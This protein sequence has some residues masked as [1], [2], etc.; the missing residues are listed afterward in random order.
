MTVAEFDRYVQAVRLPAELLWRIDWT[1]QLLH[2]RRPVVSLKHSEVAAYCDWARVRLPTEEEWEWAAAGPERRRYPWGDAEP[3]PALANFSDSDLGAPTD[4]GSYPHGATPSGIHDMAGN[5]F[6]WT[7]S[8]YDEER[9]V[10]RGGCYET[11]AITLACDFRYW[12]HEDDKDESF[13]F[14]VIA[15]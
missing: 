12:V 10:L 15:L 9:W 11:Y 2:P 8:R 6:E 4:V 5:V 14:R 7:S 1:E 3:V 13:G